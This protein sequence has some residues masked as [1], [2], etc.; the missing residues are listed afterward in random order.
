[1]QSLAPETP[2]TDDAREGTAA[3]EV[4]LALIIG[5]EPPSITSNG[6][7]VD[8]DMIAHASNYAAIVR[9]I[10]HGAY[11]QP[12]HWQA[13][14]DVE[15]R[16]NVDAFRLYADT[17]TIHVDDFKYGYRIVEPRENWQ[18]IAGA[19][20]AV[21]RFKTFVPK[22]FVLGIYQ[23]RPWHEDGPYRTW[24][25]TLDEL[26]AY[27]ARIVDMLSALDDTLQTGSHCANCA[28]AVSGKCPA[29][30]RA[31]YNAV[32]VILSSG[33][34][35]LDNETL[36]RELELLDRI[37]EAVKQRAQYVRDIALSRVQAGQVVQGWT[38]KPNYGHYKWR[39]LE[40]AKKSTN[41]SLVEEKPISRAEAKRRGASDTW[42]KEHTERP[43][44][45]YSLTRYDADKAAR[46]TAGTE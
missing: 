10:E 1:M 24:T 26:K 32:D 11:E 3:H 13:T 42:L 35:E 8:S 12:V 9:D 21:R 27:H 2:N 40:A 44:I 7:Q 39:D 45:G 36:S 14:P 30:A 31:F 22:R 29:F 15:V 5:A 38:S 16:C 18:L 28:G 46:K 23:P 37:E 41:I 43:V 4:A 20:G 6:W 33:P 34:V 25:I 17:E 19:I